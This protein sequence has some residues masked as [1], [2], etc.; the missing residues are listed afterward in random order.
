[1]AT[2]KLVRANAT[3]SSTSLLGEQAGLVARP[4]ELDATNA[5]TGDIRPVISGEPEV[6]S[7]G[8]ITLTHSGVVDTARFGW[9]RDEDDETRIFSS[10]SRR[11]WWGACLP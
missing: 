2:A 1:M 8:K 3:S 5:P 11:W 7:K 4:P 10:A 9:V 6:E